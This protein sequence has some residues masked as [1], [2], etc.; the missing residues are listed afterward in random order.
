MEFQ[1]VLLLIFNA[2]LKLVGVYMFAIALFALKPVKKRAMS[3][4]QTRFAILIAARN[5]EPS[6]AQLVE[7]LLNQN[8]PEHLRDIYVIPNN[9]TDDTE[10]AARRAG[11]HIIRCAQPVSFKGDA[12]CQAVDKLMLDDY[13]AFCVFD[14]G[15]IVHADYLAWTNTSIQSGARVVRGRLKVKNPYDSPISGCYA[16]WF[17]ML[18]VFYNRARAAIGLSAKIHGTALAFTCEVMEKSG[19]WSFRA[20]AEDAQFG[21]WCALNN[22]RVFFAPEAIAYDEAPSDIR[23]TLVQRH[24]WCG[25]VMQQFR[26]MCLHLWHY[27]APAQ[28]RRFALDAFL[29]Y[30]APALSVISLLPAALNL[31][32]AVYSGEAAVY[33]SAAVLYALLGFIGIF[34]GSFLLLYIGG[35]RDARVVKTALMY[36]VF[37]ATWLP[38][39]VAAFFSRKFTWTQISHGARREHGALT[40]KI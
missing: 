3:A 16:A 30:L 40:P 9:C 18:D 4:P 1:E 12:L 24:R 39:Q 10:G 35:Y 2:V 21:V 28:T 31:F 29:T 25:G 6:I 19:G 27:G 15:S 13:D 36:P 38:I 22:E 8:Y 20:L 14:A 32:W 34:S 7:S 23:T 5:E 17:E 37:L 11:A 33:F 26:A